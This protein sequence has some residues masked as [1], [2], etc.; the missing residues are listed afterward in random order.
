MLCPVKRK[1]KTKASKLEVKG[2]VLQTKFCPRFLKSTIRLGSPSAILTSYQ[3]ATNLGVPLDS[4]MQQSVMITRVFFNSKKIYIRYTL[5]SAKGRDTLGRI[6]NFEGSKE[7][8]IVLR[9]TLPSQRQSVV[10]CITNPGVSAS[11]GVQNFYWGLFIYRVNL[12]I[13]G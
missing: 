11:F 1:G 8:Y 12:I 3:L 4:P 2:I 10:V 5:E 7:A 13:Y 9:D 6:W